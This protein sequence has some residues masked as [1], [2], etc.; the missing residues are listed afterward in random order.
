M[1]S[2]RFV[3]TQGL[4]ITMD[5][6]S[7]REEIYHAKIQALVHVLRDQRTNLYKELRD[8]STGVLGVIP[9]CG[10]YS[11]CTVQ[12]VILTVQSQSVI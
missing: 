5:N 11:H 9:H 3:G 4:V 2:Y 6:V 1:H 7:L 12:C 8:S 10:E